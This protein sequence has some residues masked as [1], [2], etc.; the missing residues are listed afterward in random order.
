ME[1]TIMVRCWAVIWHKHHRGLLVFLVGTFLL[2]FF[3]IASMYSWAGKQPLTEFAKQISR[4][5]TSP[6]ITVWWLILLIV[7]IGG[8]AS[9]L[10]K[11][12]SAIGL[13]DQQRWRLMS[14][15]AATL[16]AWSASLAIADR[17]LTYLYYTDTVTAPWPL[18]LLGV[19]AWLIHFGYYWLA[20]LLCLRAV[21]WSERRI[22]FL[23]YFFIAWI[24]AA[25]VLSFFRTT[26]MLRYQMTAFLNRTPLL[27]LIL[28]FGT[29]AFLSWWIQARPLP[30]KQDRLFRNSAKPM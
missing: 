2:T 14:A 17:T 15:F 28:E 5:D 11:E 18:P 21:Q 24:S 3:E 20:A 30:V 22:Q 12:L 8:D 10:Q 13:T 7:F 1:A 9:T 4:S 16:A 29:I 27:V 26:A 6:F 19:T 25:L 23:A